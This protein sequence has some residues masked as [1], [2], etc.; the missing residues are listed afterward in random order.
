MRARLFIILLT[1]AVAAQA[2][3]ALLE[4]V[5]LKWRPT[6][7]L[8]L[9]TLEMSQAPIQIETFQDA[10]DNKQAVGENRRLHRAEPGCCNVV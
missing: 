8:K 9:G 7:D 6:S 4:H 3:T 5:P 2:K 10:R 1:L